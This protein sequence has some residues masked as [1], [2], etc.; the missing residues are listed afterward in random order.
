M[1]WCVVLALAAAG[2]GPVA[3]PATVFYASGADLQSINPLLTVHPLARQVQRY[4]LFLTLARYDSALVARPYLAER[5]RWSPDR[6]A[7]ELTMRRDVRWHDGAPTTAADVAFTLNAARDPATGYPRR[8]DLECLTDARATADAT[9]RLT[10]CRPQP[11]FPDVLT[12]L[13]ILPAHLLAALPHDQLRRAAFNQRPVGNGPFRFVSYRPGQRWVFDAD[14]DFPAALGGP[15]GIRRLVV[16]VVDEAATKLAGL[17]TGELDV[18]GIQPMHAALVR[19]DPRL[20]VVDYPI[21]LTYGLVWNTGRPPFGD[22]RLRRALT[23]ALDRRAMVD[24][25]LYGFGVV[26]DGPVPP[27]HPLA[28]PV[29]RVPFDRSAS[30]ALLDSLG[31]RLGAD[32]W[33]RREGRPLAF[34]ILTV[35]AA[36]NSLEQMIQSDFAAVG[37]NAHVRQLELGAFLARAGGAARDYDALVTG[38]LGDL[39]LGYL[40]GLFDS[41]RLAEPLQ[42]AQYRNPAVDRALDAGDLGQ[43]QRIVARDLPITLLYHAR[44]LEGLS[45]RVDGV[46]MDLRGELATLQQWHIDPRARR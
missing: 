10:F 27:W 6:R 21:L 41:R 26:A 43:V 12:D 11:G 19:R 4:A 46:R 8:S 17:V 37:V 40:H 15:P 31:W 30:G 22:P 9:V 45:R 33:R 3:P 42:Y 34:T 13:A 44:G 25:Y 23:L 5:W 32:G 24:A 29:D 18:A 35:G 28:V 20:A 1:R 7:L 2:C 36:D 16:V 38:I 39:S 14:P